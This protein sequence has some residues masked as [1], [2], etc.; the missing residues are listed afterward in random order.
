MA[1][2]TPVLAFP[3]GSVAEVV[4]D[5][6]SG[7]VCSGVDGAVARLREFPVMMPSAVRAYAQQ[8][9]SVERMV[10]DYLALYREIYEDVALV[11]EGLDDSDVEKQ[12]AA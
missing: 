5:G 7:F 4:R 11:D 10:Q 12:A 9:F 8:H 3:G 6:V 2:G 1:T